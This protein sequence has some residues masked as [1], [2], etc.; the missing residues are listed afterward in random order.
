SDSVERERSVLASLGDGVA[1][2]DESGRI[3]SINPAL[4]RLSGWTAGEA[5]GRDHS[6]VFELVDPSGIPLP[7]EDRCLARAMEAR[8]VVTSQGQGASLRRRDGGI[9][10]VSVTASPIVDGEGRLIGGVEAI[11]DVSFQREVDQ[12]KSSLISTVSHELRTPLT[13]IQGFSE[14]LL[15]RVNGDEQARYALR[16]IN[17]SSERLGRLVTDL[18]SVSRIEAGR[19]D[20]NLE[21]VR[22]EDAIRA[23]IE[24]FAPD[25]D[26]RVEISTDQA[27]MADRDKLYQVLTN[28][29]SNATKYSAPEKP[30]WVRVREVIEGTVELSVE[31]Q[32]LG[33]TDEEVSRLFDKFFR[34]DR[35]EVR[36]VPGT[37]L[38]L[39]ITKKL[40]ELQGG[41]VRA[42]SAPGTGTTMSF[43][44]PAARRS[45]DPDL[46]VQDSAPKGR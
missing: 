13:M 12:L 6:E 40:V 38:G 7:P 34:A 20:V 39:Y 4:E 46:E 25:R 1:I 3:A 31:D 27:I 17:D 41:S 11:R 35:D 24:P 22:A 15:A 9:V 43:T 32:G 30:V 23:A 5:V 26:I 36:A 19:L 21:P 37:G 8:E 42:S 18:L 33:M 2:T 28:L 29:I 45:G 14:L 16:Q 10:P 44:L